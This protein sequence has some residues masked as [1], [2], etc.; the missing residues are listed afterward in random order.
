MRLNDMKMP[1]YNHAQL[2]ILINALENL[3][4]PAYDYGHEMVRNNLLERF[5]KMQKDY[6]QIYRN[7]NRTTK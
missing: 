3:M 1:E 2:Y 4:I 7:K 6:E 5:R